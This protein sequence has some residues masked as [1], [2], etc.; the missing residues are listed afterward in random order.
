MIL[1]RIMEHIQHTS[2]ILEAINTTS[3]KSSSEMKN[4][5]HQFPSRRTKTKRTVSSVKPT[6]TAKSQ[7]PRAL[8]QGKDCWRHHLC[9][10]I[11]FISKC[12]NFRFDPN[13]GPSNEKRYLYACLTNTGK[14]L[15]LNQRCFL[16]IDLK[17]GW[18]EIDQRVKNNKQRYSIRG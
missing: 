1:Q 14:K 13:L 9:G 12:W 3:E 11:F 4:Q 8:I 6:H 7:N 18:S 16:A 15:Q 17:C 10:L 5:S 2:K